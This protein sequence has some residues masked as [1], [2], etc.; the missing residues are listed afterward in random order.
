MRTHIARPLAVSLVAVATVSATAF[1]ATPATGAPPAVNQSV[2]GDNTQ[3]YVPQIKHY[4]EAQ[5]QIA[6]LT[7][8]GDKADA[9]RIR[10]MITT[11][12][13]VWLTQGTPKEVEQ[14]ARQVTSRAADKGRVPV[15]VAYNIPFRDCA[16]YSAGGATDA[17]SYGAWIDG[18]ARGIGGRPAVVLLEPDSLGIIPWYTS[19]NGATEWCQPADAD[20]ATAAADR[21]AM[22]NHA[23]DA[24]KSNADTAVYLDGTHSA[25]L[26]AGDAADRLFKAGVERADGFFLNV[27]NYQPTEKLAKYGDWISQCLWFGTNPAEGGWRLGHFDYCASQYYPADPNDFSTW[28]L[29]D[30]WYADNVTHAANPPASSDDLTHFVIDT[31]RNGQGPWTPPAGAYPDPQDWCNPPGR[32]LGA[33]PTTATGDPLDDA[34]LWVKTPGESDG[35]CSRGLTSNGGVDPEW[36]IVDPA[37]GDWFPHQALQ[38]AQLANP[39]L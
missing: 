6:D 23:V 18:V 5:A 31:S 35:Q 29:T 11:P 30:Q 24:L 32:G 25:W 9:N 39:A 15:L 13:A 26:G 17:A 33:R 14:Q 38:L 7:Q 3:F 10:S 16:Q 22:L 19:I 27:S 4:K 37:A 12:Q 36:G 2:I 34:Y 1:L 21:F 28:G 8:K 20:P